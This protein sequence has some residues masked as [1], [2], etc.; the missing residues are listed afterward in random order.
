[1]VGN[2]SKAG[3]LGSY[4]P[5]IG[6]RRN[7]MTKGVSLVL[8]NL[9]LAALAAATPAQVPS[10]PAPLGFEAAELRGSAS[11]SGD[12]QA[13]F[14]AGIAGPD[15]TSAT[16]SI[17]AH[18]QA[19]AVPADAGLALT[20]AYAPPN[21]GFVELATVPLTRERLAAGVYVAFA[22]GGA[23]LPAGTHQIAL[24]GAGAKVYRTLSFE[25]SPAAPPRPAVA[26]P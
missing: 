18:L 22:N 20:W 4:P 8:A 25:V 16:R 5:N 26:T 17:V 11:S 12:S 21:G 6:T 7:C 3:V 14:S 15:F 13:R 23:A 19:S 2:P 24:V 10:A 9:V 1:A